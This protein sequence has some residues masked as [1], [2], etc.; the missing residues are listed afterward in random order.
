MKLSDIIAE[1]GKTPNAQGMVLCPIHDE[2]TPSCHISPDKNMWFCF[3]CGA[4]GDA[5]DWL[6]RVRG[7]S[8]VDALRKCG[9]PPKTAPPN[10][11]PP[12][13]QH[14]PAPSE[15]TED[16]LPPGNPSMRKLARKLWLAAGPVI[17][18]TP[19][20][21]NE[22]DGTIGATYL[23]KRLAVGDGYVRPP[24]DPAAIRW[25]GVENWPDGHRKP[26]AAGAILF[27]CETREKRLGLAVH[28]MFID[29]D[30]ERVER[31][32]Y[33]TRAAAMFF[34]QHG[35]SGNRWHI[36]EGELDAVALTAHPEISPNET[37][38]SA[39][40]AQRV[41]MAARL[42]DGPI[43]LWLDSDGAGADVLCEL[44]CEMEVDFRK[45]DLGTDPLDLVVSHYQELATP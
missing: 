24:L 14:S 18:A 43:T 42:A 5:V 4:G 28:A 38:C 17:S 36:C 27:R 15:P 32:T 7:L 22:I 19:A 12:P 34:P 40:G 2:K 45:G 39:G 21:G 23:R 6:V 44:S 35:A 10:G 33:G 26:N 31:K 1:D 8:K 25:I 29:A 16:Q 3:G 30:G 11:R 13:V 9:V 41:V 20:L 37:V